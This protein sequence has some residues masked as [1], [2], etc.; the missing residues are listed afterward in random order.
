MRRTK[1]YNEV[2]FES[3]G[4]IT[5]FESDGNKDKVYFIDKKYHFILSFL[6]ILY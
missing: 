3:G 4:I 6:L 2:S 5:H 1:P